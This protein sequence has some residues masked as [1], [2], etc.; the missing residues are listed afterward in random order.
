MKLVIRI[1]AGIVL[2]LVIAIGGLIG[3]QTWQAHKPDEDTIGYVTVNE[4]GATFYMLPETVLEQT[5][6]E[7][8]V[9]PQQV[10]LFDGAIVQCIS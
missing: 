1:F 8:E 9:L 5:V 2:T 7:E 4:N 10:V 3:Y 6:L